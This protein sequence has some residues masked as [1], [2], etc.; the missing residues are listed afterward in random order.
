MP[1]ELSNKMLTQITGKGHEYRR[2]L[3]TRNWNTIFDMDWLTEYDQQDEESERV[4]GQP[5]QDE[6]EAMNIDRAV[7][8]EI[9]IPS[10]RS[11][12]SNNEFPCISTDYIRE[13][14]KLSTL[15]KVSVE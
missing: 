5:T 1:R 10:T 14:E 8:A 4:D 6:D 11:L 3:R 15:E 2:N 7:V 9:V 12:D 13:V